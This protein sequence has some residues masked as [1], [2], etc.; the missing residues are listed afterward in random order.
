MTQETKLNEEPI[1]CPNCGALMAPSDDARVYSC[2][3]CKAQLVAGVGAGQLARGMG[4]DL[5]NTALAVGQ[6]AS[7]LEQVFPSRVAI[8]RQGERVASFSLDMDT[9]VFVAKDERHGH[10][11]QH[12]RMSRGVALRTTRLGLDR[13]VELLAQIVAAHASQSAQAARAAA[14]LGSK[15]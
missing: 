13:W 2:R 9:D 15:P 10:V 6:I 7:Y 12:R 1:F 14:W 8:E 11:F 4:V 3:Y 5:A